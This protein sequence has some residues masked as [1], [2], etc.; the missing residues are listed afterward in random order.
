MS[1]IL[2]IKPLPINETPIRNLVR[3]G[4]FKLDS[5][6]AE[7]ILKECAVEWQRD[8]KDFH[9]ALFADI[10]R[11]DTWYPSQV[12]FGVLDNRLYLLN[13]YHRLS[14]LAT[15]G[16]SMEVQ[17]LFIDC[18]S[19]AELRTHYHRFDVVQQKRSTQQ[20]LNAI[21][22]P[23]E[24]GLSRRASKA[25]YDA[26]LLIT[27]GFQRV[28][29]QQ[30]PVKVRSVDKRLEAARAWWP[31]MKLYEQYTEAAPR[32]IK[33]R[34]FTQGCAAVGLVTTLYQPESAREFW[35]GLA[36]D[37][38]LAKGDPRK[39]FLE[40]MQRRRFDAGATD[41]SVMTAS[42]AWNAW[43]DARKLTIIKIAQN[44]KIRIAGTPFDGSRDR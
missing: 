2:S 35:L 6:L 28:R 43:F 19:E 1:G 10:L 3:Q 24:F 13:G 16:G 32:H 9:V 42:L 11:R 34:L 31:V 38:G 17:V 29:Y 26:V 41:Q 5:D 37:D 4:N 14:A 20:I 21:N 18:E 27:S 36:E 8:I 25:A 30:D 39:T 33:Q 15:V 23:G 7:R 12:A 40:D 22:V 44:A